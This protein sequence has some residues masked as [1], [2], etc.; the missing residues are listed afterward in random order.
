MTLDQALLQRIREGGRDM[1]RGLWHRVGI[2]LIVLLLLAHACLYGLL[3]AL[4]DTWQAGRH[5]DVAVAV[6]RVLLPIAAL[7]A[8]CAMALLGSLRA[9]TVS[10]P[11]LRSLGDLVLRD[12]TRF[13]D[14][15]LPGQFAA[16]T[17]PHGLARLAQLRDLP[18][19]LLLARS[20][21]R[22]D[23]KPLL[24]AAETGLGREALIREVERQARA[25]AAVTIRR[26]R[27]LVWVCFGFAL[28]L[29]FLTA[30]RFH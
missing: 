4:G 2:G 8:A 28:V 11:F 19:I 16:L 3:W 9:L 14:P 26:V 18:L 23:V 29:P 30:W 13:S 1:R 20:I 21:L 10:G 24:Q 25:Q 5:R 6:G 17:S 7:V 15:G 27:A 12:P 22:I